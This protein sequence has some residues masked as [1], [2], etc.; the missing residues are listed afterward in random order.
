M[1]GLF[2]VKFHKFITELW[3]FTQIRILF[4]LN[5]LKLN[6]WNLAK[7]FI[8]FDIDK[9]YVGIVCINLRK[10]VTVIDLDSCH[11]WDT[12]YAPAIYN[13]GGGKGGAYSITLV[14][15]YVPY[16][17]KMVS[18]RYLLNTLVHWI[19]ISYTGI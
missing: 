4:P 8:L 16:I 17:R 5:I 1:F 18:G 15:T 12:F 9:I 13:G 6:G 10:F 11:F 2:C 7:K 3:P 14:R 19:H